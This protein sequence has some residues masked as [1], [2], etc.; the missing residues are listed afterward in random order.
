MAG[1]LCVPVKEQKALLDLQSGRLQSMEVAPITVRPSIRHHHG[2]ML[3]RR[4]GGKKSLL[5]QSS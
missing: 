2:I 4:R 5:S 1:V 3:P